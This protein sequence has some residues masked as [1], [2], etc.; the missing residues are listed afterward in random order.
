[1][2]Q[3]PTE[4]EPS[5]LIGC[6]VDKSRSR[7]RTMFGEIAGRY[8]FMNHLLA[9]NI[10]RLW[11]RRMVRMVPPRDERPILDVCSGTGDLALAYD[12]LARYRNL[13]CP[14]VAT[15]FC[16]EMLAIGREKVARSGARD[17]ITFIEADTIHLPFDDGQFQIVAVSFGLRNVADTDRG[18]AEMAR[19]CRPGGQVAVLEFSMPRKQPIRGIYRWYFRHV[20]PRVG[21][22]L[23][24]NATN[25]Y[26]YL[27]ES[28]GQFPQADALA[29][30]M[31]VA[32]L[33]AV[34]FYPFTGGI[35]TL[36]V[37]HR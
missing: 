7:I 35:A 5:D 13:A 37:G 36:Y 29:D 25:A 30:R 9:L 28:V 3:F 6:V 21:Q 19:V 15:D 23:T 17:R 2:A 16:P 11:R 14:I 10:D 20:L 31:R 12:R 18:L 27:P 33:N 24:R 22:W 32:G 4:L 26:V 34:R 1:M 8:D